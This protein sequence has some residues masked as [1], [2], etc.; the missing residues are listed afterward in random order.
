MPSYFYRARDASG[1]AHEGIEVAAS[2]EEVLRILE[3]S[4][5]IPIYVESRAP[6]GVLAVRGQLAREWA[7]VAQ[8]MRTS[9]KPVAVALFAR[10]LSTMISAGLPL[11]RSLRSISRDH[12]DKRLGRILERVSDDVQKGDSL[13]TALG[14]HPGAF[15]EVFVSLVNTGEV[16]GTLD[17][18]MDQTA[19]YL[20]RAETLR[21][22]VQAA[23]RYPMFVL[24]I[25]VAMLFLMIIWVIPKFSV[26]Y[27]QFRVPLPIPT[28]LVLGMS[29][30]A[31][32]NLPI[33]LLLLLLG[34]VTVW[35][36]LR[37]EMGRL[38]WDRIKFSM[39]VF[40]P[41]IRLYAITKFART[42]S[43]LTGSGTQIL[44]SLKVIR[45]VPGNKVLERGIDQVRSRVEE[46][47]ALAK[48]MADTGVFPEMLVQMTATGEETGQLD[49]MLSR[50]ADFYE[51]RVTTQVDGLSSLIEPI[52]IVVLGGMVGLMLL[53]LYL[54]IFNLGQAMRSGLLQH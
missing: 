42:L 27:S 39:P 22:K 54:P 40:G 3:H 18:I 14:K 15:D 23:L 21:L 11:V 36:N 28:Q 38:W 26:I 50:T 13:S 30:L 7:D 49:N 2:E 53:A 37:K 6:G 35:Y 4:K 41:L 16:S 48:A 43:I 29:Q 51:Q 45:P 5:L 19:S 44:Y 12:E 32:R 1:K 20:E 25:A 47:D 52:A 17:T 31:V 9:V 10:Q 8:R 34:W 24:G 46:G 33:L